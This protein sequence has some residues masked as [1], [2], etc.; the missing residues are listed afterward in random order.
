[1]LSV[2]CLVPGNYPT[3]RRLRPLR[4]LIEDRTIAEKSIDL[5]LSRY[6]SSMGCDGKKKPALY[7]PFAC[8]MQAK[9]RSPGNDLLSHEVSLEVSSAL[10]SL[11]T[12][13]GMGTGV[14]PSLLPPEDTKA[15]SKICIYLFF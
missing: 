4:S 1:M 6:L 10:K 8:I 15:F 11:T 9:L 3:A 14:S 13:F 7:K 12:V 2:W 5:I